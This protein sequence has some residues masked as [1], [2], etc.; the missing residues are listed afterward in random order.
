MSICFLGCDVNVNL[1]GAP[2]VKGSGVSKTETREV[3]DFDK[4]E[5][6]GAGTVN[7]TFGDSNSLEISGDDNLL[8]L[9]ETKVEDGKLVIRPTESINPKSDLVFNVVTKDLSDVSVAGAASLDIKEAAIETLKVKVSGAAKMSGSGSI[10]DLDISISGAGSIA[11]KD[12]KSKD[13]KI[14]VSGA[15]SA[16][17]YASNSLDARIAGIG[18]ITCHGNPQDVNK[19]TSGL[20]TIKIVD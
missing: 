16:T 4:L 12:M 7:L 17:V 3:A 9:I 20:G 14:S 11:L 8:P 15:A 18:K 10:D 5:F 6:N 2:G 1:N 13:V 19:T